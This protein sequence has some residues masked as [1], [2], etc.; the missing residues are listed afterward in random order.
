MEALDVVSPFH[1]FGRI[2]RHG[3]PVS[4]SLSLGGCGGHTPRLLGPSLNM[5]GG[6][7]GEQDMTLLLTW[8]KHKIGRVSEV[9]GWIV[10]LSLVLGPWIA[11]FIGEPYR[12]HVVREGE[13]CAPGHRWTY[14]QR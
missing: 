5:L 3:L 6:K 8:M 11:W 4:G 12:R 14:A 9:L 1:G 2:L 13:L 7:P 10:V